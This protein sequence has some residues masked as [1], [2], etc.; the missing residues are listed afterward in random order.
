LNCALRSRARA[1][2]GNSDDRP[3]HPTTR[4]FVPVASCHPP[5]FSH[6]A[7]LTHTHAHTHTPALLLQSSKR[8]RETIGVELYAAQQTLSRLQTKLDQTND[9]LE[10]TALERE[11]A[12]DELRE[13]QEWFETRAGEADEQ[14]SAVDRYQQELD[15]LNATLKHVEAHDREIKSE[16]AVTRTAAFAAEEAVGRLE[17]EKLE[18]DVLIDSLQATLKKLH[19]QAATLDAQIAAQ[20][21]ETEA[22]RATL[23]EANAEMDSV[24]AEKNQLLSQWKSALVGNAKRDEALAATQKALEEQQEKMLMI[25]AETSANKKLI[26]EQERQNERLA[27]LLAKTEAESEFLQR[28][29]QQC[30]DKRDKLAETHERLTLSLEET[31]AHL[32][33]AKKESHALDK[34]LK[35]AE[36]DATN[37]RQASRDQDERMLENLS[38]QTTVEKGAKRLV[39][40]TKAL[41]AKIKAEEATVTKTQ[42]EIARLKVD[43]LNVDARN[44]ALSE[45]AHR[46]RAELEEKTRA[47]EKYE[48]EIARRNDEIDKKASEVER[49]NRELAAKTSGGGED[50]NLGPME[51]T[52]KNATREIA[53][54]EKASKELQR[55][56]VG[57]QTDL[58]ATVNEN[59]QLAEKTQRLKAEKT[60]LV[61]RRARLEKNR[62]RQAE[63]IRALDKASDR[64]HADATKINVA[65]AKNARRLEVLETENVVL[66]REVVGELRDLEL[67]AAGLESKIEAAAEE[68]RSTLAEVVEAERQIMLWERKIQLEKETQAALDPDVGG[69]VVT[70]MKKEIQR[71]ERRDAE[72][73][74]RQ[75][76]LMQDM[77]KAIYKRELIMTKARLAKT[78]EAADSSAARRSGGAKASGGSVP[79]PRGRAAQKEEATRRGLQRQCADLKR[80]IGEAESEAA[81]AEKNLEALEEQRVAAEEEVE[82]TRAAVEELERRR[83][84]LRGAKEGVDRERERIELEAR[85]ASRMLERFGEVERGERRCDA[86]E[87][88]AYAAFDEATRRREKLRGAV[89]DIRSDAPHLEKA[90]ERAS[91][92]LSI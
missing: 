90:L 27:N 53:A 65:S 10:R 14:R 86:T 91:L 59:N 17:K 69:D 15:A 36:R 34:E 13:L 18:Q 1:G 87:E 45:T 72:L 48:T 63:E 43:A 70:A 76:A 29:I 23:A 4:A 3:T 25:E 26:R 50:E 78:K 20:R 68:K 49:L 6:R 30:R 73:M 37:A 82:A 41:R 35:N 60:V 84:E 54:K 11:R 88:E 12:E 77:E 85:K 71:M 5:L 55:R 8:A 21:K 46:L 74:R 28:T 67:E 38:E 58:V 2:F 80:S 56:W 47:I 75:E 16:I 7:R 62:Q 83:E 31:E 61:A 57:Y 92:L 9:A 33:R 64:A 32:D 51:A 22:A 81:E 19:L 52:I 24:H 39:D 44:G 79:P 66:E 40:A 89:E 42:N